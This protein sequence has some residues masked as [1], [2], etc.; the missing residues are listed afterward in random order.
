M[1]KKIYSLFSDIRTA[2]Y[3]IQ[4]RIEE[5]NETMKHISNSLSSLYEITVQQ[6]NDSIQSKRLENEAVSFSRNSTS[7]ARRSKKNK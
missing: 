1:F 5:N 3:S 7:N 2:L 4:D 6:R